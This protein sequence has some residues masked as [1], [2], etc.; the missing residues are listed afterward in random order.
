[1]RCVEHDDQHHEDLEHTRE[2]YADTT[3]YVRALEKSG[4][5]QTTDHEHEPVL[6][7]RKKISPDREA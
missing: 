3:D 2:A 4:A 6:H 7:W 1:M 5:L